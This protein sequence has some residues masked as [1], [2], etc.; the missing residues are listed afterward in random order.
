MRAVTLTDEQYEALLPYLPAGVVAVD[1]T[2]LAA[3]MA[4]VR[5]QGAVARVRTEQLAAHTGQAAVLGPPQIEVH[6]TRA[7]VFYAAGDVVDCLA[8]IVS[9]HS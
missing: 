6:R 7:P 5:E 2:P 9:P 8:A 4:G 3:F 1:I